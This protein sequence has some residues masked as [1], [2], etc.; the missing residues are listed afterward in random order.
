MHIWAGIDEA[1]YGPRLGPLVV[2]ACAFRVPFPPKEGILWSMLDD[3]VVRTGTRADGRIVVDDS[4]KV[5]SSAAN[6]RRLEEGVLSFVRAGSEMPQHAAELLSKVIAGGGRPPHPPWFEGVYA[7]RLPAAS[8]PS[9]VE[10]KAA[11]LQQALRTA[12]VGTPLLCAALVLTEE[13]NRVVTRTG[14]KSY[15]LFQKCGLLLQQIWRHAGSRECCILVDRHGGRIRYRE[16]L[17]DV[18]PA[19]RCEVLR[20]SKQGSVYRFSDAEKS[21]VVAFK[22]KADCLALPVALASML[23]KYLRELYMRVFN[24]YWQSR[25]Q[26]LKGTAGYGNDARRFFEEISPL[27]AAD[28]IEP[29]AIL[30]CR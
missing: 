10:S 30:R 22:E 9:A 12:G 19:C 18:F 14:N 7:A 3:A 13:F 24:I 23:A 20:E 5:Y 21:L 16:L 11:A 29:A 15:L 28:G 25:K 17:R 6:L 4:K 2:G 8:N 26:G 27:L 1:G